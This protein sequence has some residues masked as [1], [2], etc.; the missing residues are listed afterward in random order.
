[1]EDRRFELGLLKPKYRPALA[2]NVIAVIRR[3]KKEPCRARPAKLL[4]KRGR[5]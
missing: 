2:W 5:R 3:R 4:V 1:M